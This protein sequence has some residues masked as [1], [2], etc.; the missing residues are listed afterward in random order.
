[1][2]AAQPLSPPHVDLEAERRTGDFVRSMIEAGALTAVHD[3]SDGGIAVTVAEMALAGN[4]GALLMPEAPG[5]V[6][7]HYFAEDQGLYVATVDDAALL[8]LLTGGHAAGVSVQRIG[9]TIAKRIVFELAEGDFVA[10][11]ADLRTA[12]E[13]FFPA[14]MGENAALA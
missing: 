13:G 8:D 11:L 7:E 4:V 1:M 5:H 12:H 9:R 3:V 2:S 14:L 6:A 10:S